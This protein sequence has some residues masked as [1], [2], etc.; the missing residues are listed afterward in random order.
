MFAPGLHFVKMF[1]AFEM[2][3]VELIH[4]PQSLQ[5]IDGAINGGSI[6]I[7]LPLAGELEQRVRI[8]MLFRVLN[9]FNYGPALRGHSDTFGAQFF[10]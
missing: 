8:Q 4:Q 1:F 9:D 3:E 10:H 6:D 5:K 2:H 7:G